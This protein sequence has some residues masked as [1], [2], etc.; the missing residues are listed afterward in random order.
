MNINFSTNRSQ[1][2]NMENNN[3]DARPTTEEDFSDLPDLVSD[4]EAPGL[5]DLAR[6]IL[7]REIL[8][9]QGGLFHS[10]CSI[11]EQYEKAVMNHVRLVVD[12]PASSLD[13]SKSILDL[14]HTIWIEHHIEDYRN[15]LEARRRHVSI[16]ERSMEE[17]KPPPRTA[18]DEEIHS[19]KTY[20][21]KKKGKKSEKQSCVICLN[22][23][24][25]G[26][27]IIETHCEHLFHDECLITWL[28]TNISCPMCR[29]NAITGENSVVD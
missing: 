12:A 28:K 14:T 5:A 25:K 29:K 24:Q 27:K 20:A 9:N 19:L 1:V 16:I 22:D 11:C 3:T 8:S 7:V 10:A 26:E 15:H 21:Y 23:L 4:E 13:D 17:S 6:L 18:N 2:T